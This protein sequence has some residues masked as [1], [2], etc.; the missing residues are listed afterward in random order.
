M[1]SRCHVLGA[2]K[3]IGTA[4]TGDSRPV[5]GS[6]YTLRRIAGSSFTHTATVPLSTITCRK[7][8]AKNLLTGSRPEQ[9]SSTTPMASRGF[10]LLKATDDREQ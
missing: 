7:S 9:G 2:E 10:E 1:G 3:S 8:Q 4:R 6:G 5:G